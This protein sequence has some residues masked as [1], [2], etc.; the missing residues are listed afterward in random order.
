MTR[1]RDFG[2]L[3]GEGLPPD[4]EARLRRVHDLLVDAGPPPELPQ[5]LAEPP[6][7]E[8]RVVALAQRRLRTALI[9]AAAVVLAAFAV[10]YF[11]GDRKDGA[12]SATGFTA[13]RTVV[14]GKAGGRLAVV[15]IGER[16]D[17]GN[18]PMLVR[19]EG[20][21]HLPGKN[22]YTLFMTRH[23]KPIVLCG[24]FNV[25]DAESTTVRFN[26]A[27]DLEGFDGLMLAEYRHKGHKDIPLLRASL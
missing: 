20:L 15:D 25:G 5:R 3:V 27:Y 18:R 11:I 19:T 7:P 16:D 1:R 10:G 13:A 21:R 14:L 17:R 4:E 2:E 24:S 6:R 23:G 26:V 9:L 22:Y 12:G 8:G